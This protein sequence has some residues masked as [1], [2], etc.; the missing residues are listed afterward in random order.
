MTRTKEELIEDLLKEVVE[1]GVITCLICGFHLE[2]DC[3]VC[4]CGWENVLVKE[5]YV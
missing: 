5:G 1:E 3:E 4:Q 2:S